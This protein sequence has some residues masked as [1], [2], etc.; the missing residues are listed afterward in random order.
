VRIF[1][2][3]VAALFIRN[4]LLSFL[5][6]IGLF[7]VLDMVFKF[8]ELVEVADKGP[9]AV[10]HI[11]LAIA[12]YYFHQSFLFFAH[13]CGIIPVVAAAFTLMRLSRF[14]ELSAMLSAGVPLLRIAMPIIV[15]GLLLNGL[16]IIDQELLIPRMIDKLTRSADQISRGEERSFPISGMLDDSGAVLVASR[17]FP[18]ASP[19]RLEKLSIIECDER[20]RPIAH[21]RAEQAHWDP[22]AH[23]WNLADGQRIA[24]GEGRSAAEPAH[25]YRGSITPEE[26]QLW[27]SGDYVTLLSTSRINR[28]LERPG[29]YGRAGLLRIKHARRAQPLVNIT[30]LLLA[31]ASVLTRQREELTMAAT[32]CVLLCG[33]CLAVTFITYHMAKT[34]TLLAGPRLADLWPALMAFLPVFI[35]GPLAVWLLDR[36]RT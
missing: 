25:T 15:A 31:V 28:L 3:Y 26:I 23:A 29:S 32:K 24:I 22:N 4:Y 10:S 8:D 13:L 6:L 21:I 5:V 11:L 36:V 30:L 19:P 35:F 33:A 1:D 27:R 2:R 16:L 9:G 7:V 18:N 34:D 17:Y 12:D 14:N 20:Y